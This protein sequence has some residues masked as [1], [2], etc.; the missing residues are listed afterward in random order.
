M[1]DNICMSFILATLLNYFSF[2][3]LIIIYKIFF[4][5]IYYENKK[6]KDT[7]TYFSVFLLL[8]TT[9]FPMLSFVCGGKIPERT[10][11]ECVSYLS[12]KTPYSENNFKP[13][14]LI[15]SYMIFVLLSIPITF[16]P[17]ALLIKRL[18]KNK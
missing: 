16:L 10:F 13:I 7:F 18:L 11:I 12:E 4:S 9:L 15:F 17:Q 5:K 8:I 3:L 6:L 1:K 14:I 2:F